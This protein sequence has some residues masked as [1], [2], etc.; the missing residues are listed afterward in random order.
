MRQGLLIL[1]AGPSGAGKDTLIHSFQNHP[2]GCQAYVPIRHVTRTSKVGEP[3]VSVTEK[4]FSHNLAQNKYCLHWQAHGLHY[5]IPS[6][7][8]TYLGSGHHVLLNI[9]RQ[10]IKQAL[11]LWQDTRVC[12]LYTNESILRQRLI[13]RQR[14]S[15]H[16]IEKRLERNQPCVESAIDFAYTRIDTSVSK[17]HAL[18]QFIQ[19]LQSKMG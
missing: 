19:A 18:E 6:D 13:S 14:E 1:I 5:G 12:L 15:I 10:H 4:E 8:F 17:E 11:T 3:I 9:S 16:E 2:S 7:I